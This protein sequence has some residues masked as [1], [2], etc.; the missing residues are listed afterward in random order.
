M[1]DM[2]SLVKAYL[3]IRNEREKIEAEYEEKDKKLKEDMA[4]LEREMLAGCNEMNIQSMRTAHGTVIKSLKER[5]TCADRDN[6][7]KFVLENDAVELF[8]GRIHQGNFKQFMAERHE[9][10]LPPGVNVTREFTITVRKPT[11]KTDFN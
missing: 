2:E 7:N 6:F 3:T 4:V 8:E 5:Y 1:S 10:G 9:D 11:V